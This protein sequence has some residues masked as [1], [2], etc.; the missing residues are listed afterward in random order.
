MSHAHWKPYNRRSF[1]RD[2]GDKGRGGTRQCC[3][4]ALLFSKQRWVIKYQDSERRESPSWKWGLFLCK[5]TL[6]RGIG[7]QVRQILALC[8]AENGGVF[9]SWLGWKA[10]CSGVLSSLPPSAAGLEMK[11]PVWGQRRGAQRAQP[12]P[13]QPH[14][15]FLW[16]DSKY[17][18]Y[19]KACEADA[20][21]GPKSS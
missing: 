16:S 5:D 20:P 12:E 4:L 3:E 13:L 15:V 18:A 17:S 2:A 14:K 10:S 19:V 7:R 9:S 1:I 8:G 21:P 11:V 6:C